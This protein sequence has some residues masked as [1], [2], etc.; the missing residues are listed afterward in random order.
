MDG[1]IDPFLSMCWGFFQISFE[2]FGY[3]LTLWQVFL[4]SVLA[5]G[6][7]GFALRLLLDGPGGGE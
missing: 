1:V 5:L 4:F 3:T 6:V 2:L 7:A